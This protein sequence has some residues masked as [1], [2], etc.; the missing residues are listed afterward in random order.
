YQI[1]PDVHRQSTTE[2]YS[3]DDVITTDP[4]SNTTREF[5]PFYSLRHA[6]GDKVE[7]SFWYAV[8]RA[9][10]RPDDN[11]TE[12]FMFLVDFHL[13]PFVPPVEVLNVRATC[14]NRDLPASLPS[15]GKVIVA[16]A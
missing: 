1:L 15:C 8:R 2:I 14:I 4:R 10:Q 13:Y 5:S 11:G 6:Y 9:S 12:V 7:K 16:D 3:V